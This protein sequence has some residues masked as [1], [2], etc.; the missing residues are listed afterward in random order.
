MSNKKPARPRSFRWYVDYMTAVV[1]LR[2]A[3][4]IYDHQF[5]D[6][7]PPGTLGTIPKSWVPKLLREARAELARFRTITFLGVLVT[8]RYFELADAMAAKKSQTRF[9][10]EIHSVP[11]ILAGKGMGARS[12]GMVTFSPRSKSALLVERHEWVATSARGKKDAL[13][14]EAND[15]NKQ[16][17]L[18]VA[19]VAQIKAACQRRVA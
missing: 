9:H 10:G 2:H 1:P 14:F 18:T 11:G 15:G 3:K 16:R 5:V 7:V 6:L 17:V 4:K 8:E 12:A 13:H 19:E